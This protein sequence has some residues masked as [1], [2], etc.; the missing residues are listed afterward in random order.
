MVTP[1]LSQAMGAE[2]PSQTNLIANGGDKLPGL[3]TPNRNS[4]TIGIGV[5][6]KEM[7]GIIC[8]IGVRRKIRIFSKNSGK[9]QN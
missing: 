9:A 2:V 6:E 7:Q 8:D 4:E 5:E 1:G 3:P